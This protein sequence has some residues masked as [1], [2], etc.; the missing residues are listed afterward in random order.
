MK[1][2]DSGIPEETWWNS[3]FDMAAIL[4]CV[5][6]MPEI[7]PVV[8]I[9]CGYGT[10]TVPIARAAVG[11]V[12]AFDIEAAMIER[13]RTNVA[14][15][16]LRNVQFQQRDVLVAGTGLPGV[17]GPSSC[18]TSSTRRT[19]GYSLPRPHESLS[20][21]DQPSSSTGGRTLRHLGGRERRTARTCRW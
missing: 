7:C 9:G 17:C 15:A 1:V 2:F 13:A 16:G 6:P 19:T 3:L 5:N 11:A 14:A 20:A 8:E 18:S 4:K 21:V 10:F 12:H